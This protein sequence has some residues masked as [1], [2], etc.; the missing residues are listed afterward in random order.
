MVIISL[1]GVLDKATVLI[2]DTLST[3]MVNSINRGLLILIITS[4]SSSSSISKISRV[5]IVLNPSPERLEA[6]KVPLMDP[7]ADISNITTTQE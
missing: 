6:L 7:L 5:N 4:N 2:T 3:T 1:A